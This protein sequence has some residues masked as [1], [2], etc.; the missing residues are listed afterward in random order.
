VEVPADVQK[1]ADAFREKVKQGKEKMYSSGFGGR[2]VENL[3][4]LREA[5]RNRERKSYKTG[6]EPDDEDEKENKK[7]DDD[8]LV[9]AK[10]QPAATAAA[11]PAEPAG[12]T[13]N[14]DPEIVVK[15]Y[16]AP[17]PAAGGKKDALSLVAAAKAK[18]DARL[19]RPGSLR[20]GQAVDNRGPDAG[21][22]HATLEINDFPQRARWAV[23]NRTNV[24]KI[25]E[26]TGTSITTKGNFYATGKEP[27]PTDPP[28]LYIL[29]EGDTEVVVTTAMRELLAL[30]KSGTQSAAD[31][32]SRA[33]AG[34]YSVL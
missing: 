33:P 19:N 27:G 23:T 12:S 18:I 21:E 7:A 17:P 31:A 2:G 3:D 28:K 20:A 1:L 34:R 14:Y 4:K 26:A 30:L 9:K 24:A 29:V 32:E 22:Y 5:E 15:K 8:I 25:L 10:I 11:T 16:E 6:D 13:L